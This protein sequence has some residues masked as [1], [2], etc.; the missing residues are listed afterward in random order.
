MANC[1]TLYKLDH[2]LE[3]NTEKIKAL[4]SEH[5]Q[6]T[7]T[8][9][10]QRLKAD[11]LSASRIL[12]C[13]LYL[14]DLHTFLTKDFDAATREDMISVMAKA[15]G[16][17][18]SP[19]TIQGFRV[20]CKMF[21]KWLRGGDTCPQEVSWIKTAIPK[22]KLKQPQV[23]TEQE[24]SALVQAC[25][26]L[27]DKAFVFCL[28]E[29]GCRIGE[30]LPIQRKDVTFDKYGATIQ[31]HGKTGGRRIRIVQSV[32]QLS[33]WLDSAH[34]KA[35][36]SFV[37]QKRNGKMISTGKARQIIKEA[38]G[39]AG[40]GKRVYLHLFRHTR[41]THLA[42]KVSES[43]LKEHFGWEQSSKMTSIYVHLA[44]T[45]T[46]NAIL[47]ANGVHVEA[48]SQNVTL[49][50]LDCPRCKEKN[51]ATS[52]YCARCG[53]P[54]NEKIALDV[55]TQEKKR[56]DLLMEILS[57]PLIGEIV[58]ELKQRKQAPVQS[59]KTSQ[60]TSRFS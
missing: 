28:Y 19:H 8:H 59:A 42:D 11:G 32:P 54:M 49:A 40:I 20:F 7:L 18:W 31:V 41:A 30:F 25:D 53:A 14:R 21:Y 46:D 57:H 15:D 3:K 1:D 22:S 34:D 52:Q 48:G 12:R 45:R 26:S 58:A 9:F 24:I 51:G 36:S 6:Q 44:G 29:S 38:A 50:P 55:D 47:K 39:R 60:L 13:L 33:L 16:L 37:W 5:D 4:L 56:E 2:R 23:L 27:R 17:P 10:I 35:P 43:V